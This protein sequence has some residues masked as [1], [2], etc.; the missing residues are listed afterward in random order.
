VIG[1]AVHDVPAY[2]ALTGAD[3]VDWDGF[4]PAYRTPR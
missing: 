2:L 3:A 1:K 4:F